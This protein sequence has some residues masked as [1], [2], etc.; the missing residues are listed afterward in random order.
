MSDNSRT[1]GN[2]N[3]DGIGWRTKSFVKSLQLLAADVV[4][5]IAEVAFLRYQDGF[6]KAVPWLKASFKIAAKAPVAMLQEPIE[7]ILDHAGNFEGKEAHDARMHLTREQRLEDLL[8]VGYHYT[9]AGAV[10]LGALVGTEKILSKAM[11]TA[12][13]PNWVWWCVD[14]PL[15]LGLIATLG[16]PAM[17]PQTEALKG[18]IKN[19]MKASGWDDEKA[20]QDSRFATV[21]IVPNYMN[22]VST[23]A[24][25]TGLH[26]GESKGMWKINEGLFKNLGELAKKLNIGGQSAAHAQ[27]A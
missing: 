9:T 13:T 1:N 17:K 19:V 21:Y 24:T 16:S 7:H 6:D 2:G 12:H 8:D 15:H 20:E 27:H 18:T 25:M 26:Y 4:Q 14:M 23:S 22:W 10:G 11:K 5:N 3:G